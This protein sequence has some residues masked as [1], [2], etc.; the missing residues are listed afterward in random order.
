[1][2]RDLAIDLGTANILVYRQG[3]GVVFEEPAVVAMHGMSG[4]VLGMGEEVWAMLGGSSGNVLA[5]RPLRGGTMTE[6]DMTQ[7]MLEMV[8]RR[9]GAPRFPR[10]RVLVAVPSASNEVE[11]RAIEEAVDFAGGRGVVLVE[12]PLAAAIGA[13]LPIHEPI[14]NLIV[15]IGGGR[16]EM[17]VVSMGGVVSGTSVNLGGFDMDAA[18]Q[19]HLRTQYGVAIGEKAA[20]EIKIAVGSAFP[21]PQGRAAVV[22]GRDLASGDAVEV[23]LNE[24]EIRQAMADT[25]HGIVE[26]ARTCLSEAPPELTHDV[27][28]TGIFL[29]GG[30]SLLRG[31]DMLLAQECEVPVHM[32][33]R[34]LETVAIGAGYMLENL[35]DYQSAFQLVRRR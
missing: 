21:A 3:E 6:F 11:R 8:L 5:V 19:E 28:E 34:P 2:G 24:A 25:I 10:P 26:T 1:M 20:E 33:E 12:E 14:G 32:T 29:T 18:I 4:D 22:T 17:A 23:K 7:Q 27:L 9:V 13:G 31:M 35:A 16:S 15:D 30:G